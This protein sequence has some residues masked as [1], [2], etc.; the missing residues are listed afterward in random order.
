MRPLLLALI[1]AASSAAEDPLIAWRAW[2]DDVFAV[3]KR[4]NRLVI[5]DLEAVWCHWCHVMDDITY[6][7]PE[8][9]RLIGERYLAVRVDQESRPDLANRYEDYGWPATIVFD[10]DGRELAKRSGYIPPR[11]MAGMLQAFIDDPTPGPSVTAPPQRRFAASTLD[12]A[13]R[14][15]M[16][17]LFAASW[18]AE[19]TG[20]GFV[21]KWLSPQPTEYSLL[22]ALDGDAEAGQ[23]ARA[24]LD[25]NLALI[26]PTWGGVYQYSVGGWD[27]PHFEK[28]VAMQADN[29]RLYSYAWSLWR[30]PRHLA[31]AQAVKGYVSSFL[32]SPDGAFF[33]SQDAD[34]VPGEHS[35]EYFLLDDAGR[36]AIGVPRV[37]THVYARENG[38]LIAALADMHAATGDGEALAMATRAARWIQAHRAL[39]DGGFMHD[40]R[41]AGGP[42]LGDTLAMA[43]AFVALHRATGDDAWL[44]QAR[45]ALAFIARTFRADDAGFT[46]ALASGPLSPAITR[47]ENLL[48]ARTANL[49][50]HLSGDPSPRAM[51]AHAMRWLSEPSIASEQPVVGTLMAARE[52][53]GDPLHITVVGAPGDPATIALLTAA[54]AWPVF[55]MRIDRV[56]AGATLDGITFPRLPSA[57]AFVCADGRC[58]TPMKD[59]GRLDQALR[60]A[61]AATGE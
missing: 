44:A 16:E 58:S 31:A 7:D 18:D 29:L 46:T 1:I 6:R 60:K 53:A 33:T 32:T 49:V 3:A 41:D 20:W 34:V 8:V 38:W 14:A 59:P 28:I 19:R 10:S 54:R 47:D 17:A 4:E 2:S 48:L 23:R 37:D 35:A 42:F 27:E 61:L 55:A 39:S 13:Q 22:L 9:V 43:K 30:D 12:D 24:T 52:V 45:A 26:D 56:D 25:A 50:G 11:P 51:A 36:R 57:A 21:H 5:L 15:G 40:E